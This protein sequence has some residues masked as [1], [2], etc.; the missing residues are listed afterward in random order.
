VARIAGFVH[1]CGA[2]AFALA[3]QAPPAAL[4]SGSGHLAAAVLGVGAVAAAAALCALA[5]EDEDPVRRGLALSVP[6]VVLY[7]ASIA[8]VTLSPAPLDGGAVQQGQLQLSALWSV[9]GVAGLILGL[10]HGWRPV[11]LASFGLLGL[12]AG[13]V[14]LYDLA[15]LTS[16]Y[17]VGSFLALGLLLLGAAFAYQRMR[18]QIT[19]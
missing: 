17:R 14:F 5:L 12:A 7:A 19:A 9:T 4:V 15:A 6:G 11:R 3:D 10:R 8:V 2:A 18:P 1:L 16:V 13:K